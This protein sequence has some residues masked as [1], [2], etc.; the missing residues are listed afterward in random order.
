MHLLSY[1][2]KTSMESE[3]PPETSHN[4]INNMP[5]RF[6]QVL[7]VAEDELAMDGC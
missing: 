6:T 1:T 3:I 2:S 4:I 5:N 7:S